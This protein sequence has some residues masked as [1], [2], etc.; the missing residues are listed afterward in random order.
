MVAWRCR[1]EGGGKRMMVVMVDGSKG[2]VL[3]GSN[4]HQDT[5]TS[6]MMLSKALGRK[7]VVRLSRERVRR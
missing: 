3:L 7:G 6:I 4:R 5:M 2:E 1:V